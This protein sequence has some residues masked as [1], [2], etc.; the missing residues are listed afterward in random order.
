MDL[1]LDNFNDLRSRL[2]FTIM[3]VLFFPTFFS[4]LTS[5]DIKPSTYLDPIL[6]WGLVIGM[7]VII[8]VLTEQIKIKKTPIVFKNFYQRQNRLLFLETICFLPLF[9]ISAFINIH[10][11]YFIW[12]YTHLVEASLFFA[13]AIP[14]IIITLFVENYIEARENRKEQA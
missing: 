12:F 4:P 7:Y 2:Q 11:K 10:N 8:F 6:A 5:G 9:F 14:V 1:N 13:A 3:L